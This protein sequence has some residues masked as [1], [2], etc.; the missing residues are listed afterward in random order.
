MKRPDLENSWTTLYYGARGS[1]KSIHQA[2]QVLATLLWRD[3][4]HLKHPQLP[5]AIVITNQKL[6]EEISQ[7]WLGKD[8][9]YWENLDQLKHCPRSN[10]WLGKEP[11]A[12]HSC[13]IIFDDMATI[14]PADSWANTPIWVRKMFAQA[15]HNGVRILANCQDPFSLDI[16]FK[17]YVDV[18]YRFQP[19]IKTRDYDA[20]KPPLR[21]IFGLYR[22]RRIDAYMLWHF[23]DLPEQQIRLNLIAKENQDEHLKAIGREY[24]IVND[25]SWKGQLHY[26]T[27]KHTKIYD[28][29]Q[30][31]KEYVPLGYKHSEFKCLNP[32]CKY[33]HTKHELI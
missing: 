1:C 27:R 28:T 21:F 8:L 33:K 11:H 4:F 17:R 13:Y 31:V 24:D 19:V 29:T 22:T 2:R 32:E 30:N 12:L 7:L 6:S 26:F 16:N 23:G 3:K 10:C 18:A 15:R 5:R 25:D 14:L 9:F 20:T